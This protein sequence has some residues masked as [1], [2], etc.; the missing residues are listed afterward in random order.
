M[1]RKL[2]G[3]GTLYERHGTNLRASRDGEFFSSP[4][5]KHVL[6]DENKDERSYMYHIVSSYLV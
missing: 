3:Q 1:L 6:N 5:T 4:R 2:A